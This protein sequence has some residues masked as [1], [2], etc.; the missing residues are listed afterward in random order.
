MTDRSSWQ[1]EVV[2]RIAA[3]DAMDWDRLAGRGSPFVRH[4][5]LSAL[6]DSGAVTA[7]TG[8]QPHHLALRDHTGRLHGAMPLYLKGHSMGEYVFDHAWADAYARAG[9]R[10]YPKL[11]GAVPFTPAT[12]PRLL[13]APEAGSDEIRRALL[14]AAARVCEDLGLSSLHV[15]FVPEGEW[16]LMGAAGYLLRMDTQF[17]WENA[18]YE[19]FE[20]FL[21]SLSS[22]KRKAI[23]RERREALASGIT[24]E[25]LSGSAIEEAHWDAFFAF[26]LDTGQRKWG[27]PYLNRAFFSLLGE[28]MGEDV[29]LVMA[30]RNGRY[31]AGAL[32]L[33]GHDTLYG[34]YWGAV[35][36]HPFLHFELCYY[37]A[38]DYAISHGFK[39]VEAG[40]Q[41]EHKLMRGYVPTPTYSAHWIP[42]PGFRK[43][44][45]AYLERERRVVANNQTILGEYTPFRKE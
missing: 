6:E 35:E 10:Y 42:D 25:V 1:V 27:R 13:A 18:G 36:E 17:H 4:A 34:R 7:R 24:I 44:V 8:W 12:G 40:A 29:V 26:Y 28:R 22:R 15:N 11:L 41:G 2:E 16:R 33:R 31:I 39:A 45:A 5:F 23:R 32:N 37:Q 14:T 30:R 38:I 21:G 3:L 19:D 43:A 20:A 9:G